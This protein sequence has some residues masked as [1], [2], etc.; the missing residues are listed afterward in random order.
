MTLAR[1]PDGLTWEVGEAP[2]Y[3]DLGLR[4]ADPD[5]VPQEPIQL[6]DG[7]WVLYG[8][9]APLDRPASFTSWR[10][11]APAPDGPWAIEA[12]HLVPLGESGTWD[13]QTA[14]LTSVIR[15]PGGFLG[16]YEG[17]APGREVR[18]DIGF[19]SSDDGLTWRKLPEPIISPGFCGPGTAAATIQPQVERWG[20]GYLA[21]IAGH[22]EPR[23]RMEV[24]AATSRDGV[25]WRCDSGQPVLAADDIPGSHGIHT[26]KSVPFGDRGVA[27]FVESLASERS[28][29]WLAIV[30]PAG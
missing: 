25:D 13:S 5:A 27:L 23:T 30:E 9:G 16:W 17:Q 1:S 4:L 28:D 12:N 11:S 19:A 29:I 7:S 3:T 15:G 8:W 21:L 22:S 20:D 14:S 2:I 18:G 6:D 24:F 26:M 10:A